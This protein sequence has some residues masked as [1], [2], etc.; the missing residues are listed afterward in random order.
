MIPTI[1]LRVETQQ[2][3]SLAAVSQFFGVSVL[4]VRS[5]AL[6]FGHPNVGGNLELLDVN[7]IGQKT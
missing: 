1:A 6:F 7:L 2:W 5:C 4:I 3:D